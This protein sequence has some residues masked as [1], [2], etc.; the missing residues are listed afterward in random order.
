MSTSACWHQLSIAPYRM[1]SRRR[2]FG[3]DLAYTVYISLTA[4]KIES[5]FKND[6]EARCAAKNR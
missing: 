2:F 1:E 3:I 6:S 5:V 4:R